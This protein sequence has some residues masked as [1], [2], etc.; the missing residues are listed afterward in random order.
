VDSLAER[1]WKDARDPM[2]SL[3]TAFRNYGHGLKLIREKTGKR[4]FFIPAA[5]IENPEYYLNSL[6]QEAYRQECS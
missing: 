2:D 4:R 6:I 1:V 3:K 5:G